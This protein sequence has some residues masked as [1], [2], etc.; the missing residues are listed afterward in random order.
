VFQQ[1][2]E[3]IDR[4]LSFAN[5]SDEKPRDPQLVE[6]DGELERKQIGSTG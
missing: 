1:P 4:V 3:D 2:A 5:V 6:L